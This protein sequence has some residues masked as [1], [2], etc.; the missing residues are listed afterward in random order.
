MTGIGGTEIGDLASLLPK[1]SEYFAF[2][3]RTH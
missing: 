1:A 2:D 3:V